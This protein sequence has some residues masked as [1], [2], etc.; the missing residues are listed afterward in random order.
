MNNIYY[1][2]T[3]GSYNKF[4]FNLMVNKLYNSQPNS[5]TSLDDLSNEEVAVLFHEYIHHLQNISSISGL[6][7]Y[8]S[9]ISIWHNT[10]N[11]IYDNNDKE[12]YNRALD[13]HKHLQFFFKRQNQYKGSETINFESL[14]DISEIMISED[15]KPINSVIDKQLKPI[16]LEGL[17]NGNKYNICFGIF[18]FLESA[19]YELEKAYRLKVGMKNPDDETASIPYKIGQSLKNH[20]AA[21]LS[22]NQFIKLILTCTQHIAPHAAFLFILQELKK[23]DQ[24]KIDD[25]LEF[26]LQSLIHEQENWINIIITQIHDGFPIDDHVHGDFIKSLANTIKTNIT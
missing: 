12:S 18:E 14:Q 2:G 25:I 8:D 20:H 3:A 22:D 24:H 21:F 4:Y 9:I 7:H 17:I 10:R 15:E 6:W 1:A 13:A 16:I 23:I 11:Y 26:N 19:A 5:V